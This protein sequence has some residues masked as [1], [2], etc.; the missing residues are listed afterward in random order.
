MG[1]F[2]GVW[3][4]GSGERRLARMIAPCTNVMVRILAG[5]SAGDATLTV[6]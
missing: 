2:G 3:A 4:R 6:F 1:C 5:S